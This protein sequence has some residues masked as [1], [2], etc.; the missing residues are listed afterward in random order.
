MS[1]SSLRAAGLLLAATILLTSCGSDE[2]P[3]ADTGSTPATTPPAAQ[4]FPDDFEVVCSGATQSKAADY[5][6][7]ETHKALYFETYEDDLLDQ[8]T[9]LPDDWTVLFDAN[10]DAYAAV[11]VVACGVRTAEKLAQK[12]EGYEDDESGTLGS[13]NWYTGTYE[14]TAYEAR[15]GTELGSTTLEATDNECPM[16]ASFDEGEDEIDMYDSPKEEDVIKF[17]KPFVQP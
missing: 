12:C 2:D 8:S 7:T 5:A 1:L 3:G 17:L 15:T 14:L 10:T 9:R 13:V 16:I 6:T 4:L 11:D